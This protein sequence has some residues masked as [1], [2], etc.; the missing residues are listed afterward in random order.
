MGPAASYFASQ[1]QPGV[2][3]EHRQV[4]PVTPSHTSGSSVQRKPVPA[5]TPPAGSRPSTADERLDSDP[6]LA[7]VD[8][9]RMGQMKTVGTVPDLPRDVVIGDAHYSPGPSRE[10]NPDIPDVN[11][12]PTY[13]LDPSKSYG[14]PIG[15]VQNYPRS[16]EDLNNLANPPSFPPEQPP[17]A[18]SHSNLSD[19]SHGYDG[20]YGPPVGNP[21]AYPRHRAP[22]PAYS[23]D[24]QPQQPQPRPGIAPNGG[25]YRGL[26]HGSNGSQ[27]AGPPVYAGRSPPPDYSEQIK[28]RDP[29]QYGQR[30][31]QR[32]AQTTPNSSFRG[33]APSQGQAD[34]WF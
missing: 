14:P 20:P 34:R 22:V 23:F 10:Q 3:D 9:P 7:S 15:Q 29:Q 13:N 18:R 19:G 8:Q 2:I 27:S 21:M 32:M 28:P 33:N 24:R 11:F 5:T 31:G 4:Q 30:S 16:S 6:K 26:S 17:H 25:S 12:G 1:G